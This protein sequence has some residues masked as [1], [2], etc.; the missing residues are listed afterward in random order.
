M[1]IDVLVELK[2][3]KINQTFSYF[4]PSF[5][6]KEVEVGK[7]VEV[8]FGSRTLEGFIIGFGTK[9]EI[10]L[11]S[12]IRVIDKYPV[13]NEELL[14]LGKYMSK[15]TLSNLISCY[16]AMLPS[17]LKASI[18][19][20]VNK[21]LISY[22]KLNK[23]VVLKGKQQEIIDLFKD[24]LILKKDALSISISATKTLLDKE[25]LTEIKKEVYRLNY[26]SA[27]DDKVVILNDEQ[28]KVIDEIKLNEFF[29]Y[30]LHGVT[31]SGK[32][33]VYM[34][35]IKEVIKEKQALIL[36]PEISLTPQI[37][38]NFYDR[39]GDVIAVLHSSLSDGEKFD[40]YRKIK[41]GEVSIV[42]GTRSAV[43]CPLDNIGVIIIDEE[44]STTYKQENNPK[45]NAVDIAIYRAKK[46]N[47]PLILGSAT[48]LLESYTRARTGV[49]KLLELKNRV[50]KNIPTTYLVDMKDEIKRGNRVFSSVLKT[51]INDR[52]K[53]GEQVILLLNR[54]GY[55]TVVTCHNC[56]FKVECPACEIP[57]TYHKNSN[58]LKCHYCGYTKSKIHVCPVCKSEDID[59]FGMGTEK[60]ESLVKETFN[61]SVIRM[62]VDTT[63][64]K[65]AHESI[66]NSFKNKEYNILIGTQMIAK[67]LD[68]HDVTLVGVIN[69]DASLNIPDFRSAERTFSLLNQVAGRSGRGDKLGEVVIQGFNVDNYSILL[70]A[71]NDYVSFYKEEMSLRKKLNYPPF[72]N[73]C[74]IKISGKKLDVLYDNAD[75]IKNFLLREKDIVVLG[76][77]PCTMPKINNVYYLQ[78]MVKYKK[79]NSLNKYL[80]YVI[81]VY[82]KNNLVDIQIDVNPI[83]I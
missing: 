77:S 7:R 81:E 40:E 19:T 13:L 74:L 23:R 73:L 61:T 56:G 5:L 20:V 75:K 22:L 25:I 68:F 8:P 49:Y 17:A 15:K 60:L 46:Y 76:P 18:N 31:G 43:F 63:S 32:T 79:T 24:D 39:F 6:E 45:Y 9:S 67:G 72:C 58:I 78:I 83:K 11:K 2:A 36:V 57:L 26:D 69:S 38:K 55:S 33:E 53:K 70:A 12:I 35:V 28:K 54:R 27:K 48:P 21:K 3:Q 62:D 34:N 47:C 4:V 41:N 30:L 44:H 52:L 80:N 42:I 1:I 82:R 10:E 65:G 64:K 14:D 66:L 37:I 50:N 59:E 29:A 16:Q 71:K 51:K